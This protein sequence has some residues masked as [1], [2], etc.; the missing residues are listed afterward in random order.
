M[1]LTLVEAAKIYSGDPIR[2]AIIEMFASSSDLLRELPIETIEGTAMR[3]NREETLPGIGFRGVNEAFTEGTGIIN[4]MTE[5]LVIAGGDLDV[6]RF[7]VQRMGAGM[8]STHEMMKVKALALKW[9]ETFIKG[10][11]TSEPREFDG[12]QVRCTGNQLIPNGTTNNGDPLSLAKLD[13]L[14]DAVDNPTH[15]LMSKAMR[16]RLSAAARL[17]NVGGYVTYELDA[18]GRRVTYYND[19]PILI[20]DK[21]NE[22]NDILPFTE[23]SN[24][25]S[26]GAKA[27]SIYC[28]SFGEGM[29]TGIQGGDIDVRDLG[30]VDDSPVYRTRVEWDCGIAIFHGRAAARLWSISDAAVVV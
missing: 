24:N 26:A 14:I 21:D 9:T 16:R 8:R 12:L 27:T 11:Q 25:A 13:E 17:Y 3:Y 28:V 19:L 23:V 5:P 30:E 7:I 4:P 2:S 22:N 15:L 29:F 18:F 20:V 6:D 1:A 10:D